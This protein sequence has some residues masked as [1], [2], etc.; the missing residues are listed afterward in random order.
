[1]P[2]LERYDSAKAFNTLRKS[3]SMLEQR[4]TELELEREA[5]EIYKTTFRPDAESRVSSLRREADRLMYGMINMGKKMSADMEELG[6]VQIDRTYKKPGEPQ[7][8]S[9]NFLTSTAPLEGQITPN[10]TGINAAHHPASTGHDRYKHLQDRLVRCETRLSNL[11][12]AIARLETD[13]IDNHKEHASNRPPPKDSEFYVDCL[14]NPLLGIRRPP[15]DDPRPVMADHPKCELKS[16]GPVGFH[17][18]ERQVLSHTGNSTRLP[19][20]LP[21]ILTDPFDVS[22]FT[23]QGFDDATQRRNGGPASPMSHL[24]EKLPHTSSN[25][26]NNL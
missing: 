16:S 19:P 22:L 20:I 4:V 6:R 11:K 5:L 17:Q 3:L 12:Q 2:P 13:I 8:V 14:G 9:G 23:V 26:E 21:N 18:L 15:Y 10:E 7:T 1:M 25:Q 24:E